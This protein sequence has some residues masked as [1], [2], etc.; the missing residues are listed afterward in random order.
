MSIIS[1]NCH[2][3][4]NP[5]AFQ[6]IKDLVVQKRPN[7]LFLCETLSKKDVVERLWVAIGFDGAFVVGV[8]GKSGG[9][10]LLWRCSEEVHLLEYGLNYIDV[11]IEVI[12][13]GKWRLTGLYGEPNRSLRRRTWELLR[14]LKEKSS[15]SWCIIG[16]FNNVTS[17]QDKNGGNPYPNWLVNGF[18]EVLE[19]CGLYDLELNGYPFTWE[20]GRGTVD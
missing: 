16:D 2:G 6:F 15:L 19:D 20:R 1:C 17:Q 13:H 7:F 12:D 14:N 4:G 10:A 11:S 9:V 3:L 18:I 5:W 8:Q